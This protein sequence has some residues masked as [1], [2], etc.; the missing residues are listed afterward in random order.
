[1]IIN[2]LVCRILQ[3]FGVLILM[4]CVIRA[5]IVIRDCGEIRLHSVRHY[6]ISYAMR[7]VAGREV[8]LAPTRP[9][10]CTQRGKHGQCAR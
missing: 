5:C 10:S 3:L 1:M 8:G 2:V 9:E 7:N 4:K 6:V